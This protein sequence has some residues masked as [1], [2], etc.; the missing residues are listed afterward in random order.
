MSVA[1]LHSRSL[2]GADAP[3]VTVEVHLGN[4]LPS[5]NIVGLPA[6]GGGIEY[7][8]TDQASVLAGIH[9][10]C[11]GFKDAHVQGFP[12]LSVKWE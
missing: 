1:V 3:P 5:F 10:R 6:S 4:G 7:R 11:A 2:A 8:L 12:V 9:R